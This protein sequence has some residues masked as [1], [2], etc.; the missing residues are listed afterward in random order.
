MLPRVNIEDIKGEH[1]GIDF[2]YYTNTKAH[3]VG[4]GAPYIEHL[5]ESH[6]GDHRRSNPVGSSWQ[7]YV[8]TNQYSR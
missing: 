1:H 7:V 3:K 5:C 8:W 4:K 6:R 2:K